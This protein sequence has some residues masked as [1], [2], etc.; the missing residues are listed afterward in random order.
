MNVQ[1]RASGEIEKWAIE[2]L[3]MALKIEP[4]QIDPGGDLLSLDVD[5]LKAVE[6]SAQLGEWLGRSVPPTVLWDYASI[7]ELAESLS[8][9]SR[10]Q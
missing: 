7:S 6:L 5:S 3:A 1:H 4:C 8:K 10:R 9:A 2:N